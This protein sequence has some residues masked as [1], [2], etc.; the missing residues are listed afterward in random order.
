MPQLLPFT[1][2][3]QLSYAFIALLFL[4][5]VY[6]VYFLPQTVELQTCRIYITKI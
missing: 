5:Y 6:S 2:I 4:T 3:S 1:F